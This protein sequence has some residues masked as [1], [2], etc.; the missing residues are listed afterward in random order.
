MYLYN[1]CVVENIKAEGLYLDGWYENVQT[2]NWYW[3]VDD[4]A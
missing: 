1:D 4:H 2:R 3:M